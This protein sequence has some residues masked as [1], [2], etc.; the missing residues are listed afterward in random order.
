MTSP[1]ESLSVLAM[2]IIH[3]DLIAQ[4]YEIYA[5]KIKGYEQF[6][7]DL[8][9]EEVAHAS[10]LCQVNPKKLRNR[11]LNPRIVLTSLDYLR[12]LLANTQRD[13]SPYVALFTALQVEKS[14]L[15]Q[16]FYEPRNDDD[17]VTRRVFSSMARETEGHI[18]SLEKA[19]KD[20]AQQRKEDA[21]TTAAPQSPNSA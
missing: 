6:W 17:N 12:I 16:R 11:Q 19:M 5:R 7:A 10:A 2:L 4:L 13:V 20:L 15:E 3:E 21:K 1:R 8:S 9:H 14:I 18:A